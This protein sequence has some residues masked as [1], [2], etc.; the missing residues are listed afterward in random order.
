MTATSFHVPFVAGTRSNTQSLLDWTGNNTITAS[1]LTYNSDGTFS[2]NGSS[3]YL[4][5]GQDVTVSPTNQGWAAEYW[6]NTSS[7]STLQ[8]FNSAEADD[9]NA[10]WLAIYTSKLAVWNVSPGYWRYGSTTIQ[11]N[12]W[13]Q[14]VFVC[15]PGGTNMRFYINGIQEGGNHVNNSWSA[16]YSALKTRY[17]GRYEY[18]GSYGRYFVGKISTVKLYNR[19]LSAA[20]VA[21]NFNALRGRYGI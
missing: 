21:Q 10:N 17:T 13:Y 14:A 1:S 2:F 8:H 11:N 3:N 7:G 5:A 19:A 15:D 4:D 20:E 18:S 12:T 16:T 9:F 6:F